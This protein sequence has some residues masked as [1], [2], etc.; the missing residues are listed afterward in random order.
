MA[1][2]PAG[3]DSITIEDRVDARKR[4]IAQLGDSRLF[5]IAGV[6]DPA[7]VAALPAK[8]APRPVF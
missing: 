7:V 6:A 1:A 2:A 4:L 8:G 5:W 3:G